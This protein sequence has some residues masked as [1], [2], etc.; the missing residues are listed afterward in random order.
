MGTFS[1]DDSEAAEAYFA[2][3]R[4]IEK[5]CELILDDKIQ[6]FAHDDSD[7]HVFF[8]N[9]QSGLYIMASAIGEALN[10]GASLS[11]IN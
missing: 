5:K 4:A 2:K 11:L 10:D 1:G 6:F 9:E 7:C 8:G 3:M